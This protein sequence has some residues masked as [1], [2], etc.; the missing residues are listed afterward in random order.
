MF[1]LILTI[2][3]FVAAKMFANMQQVHL[4]IFNI[5]Q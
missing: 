3:C 2:E 4:T 1:L 5:S